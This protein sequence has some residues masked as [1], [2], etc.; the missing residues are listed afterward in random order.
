[1]SADAANLPLAGRSVLVTRTR[2]RAAGIVDLLHERGARVVVVPLIATVPLL[3]PDAIAE[4]AEQAA[5]APE[6]RWAVFT[7]AAAVRL[8]VGAAGV[9]RLRPLRLAAVGPQTAADLR[10]HGLEV[11][12][13]AASDHSA[14]A[15]GEALVRLGVRGATVWLPCAEGAGPALPERLR[16]AGASVH[17]L[18]TYRSDMPAEAPVRLRRSLDEGVDA[19]TLTSASTAR[20]LAG[21]L[22]GRRLPDGIV[23]ACIGPQTAAE[24]RAAALPVH[25]VAV[26]HTAV[27]LVDALAGVF[28][29]AQPLR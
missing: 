3:A 25:A 4:A 8:T 14:A 16:E 20:H 7:S 12:L 9:D 18:H 19:I 24:A 26:A 15:L 21:A 29:A 5:A 10:R 2:A 13:V 22:A 28:E 27:G 17:V 23:V 11:D 6:P 1:M